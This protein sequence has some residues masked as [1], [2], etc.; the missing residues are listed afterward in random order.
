[1]KLF[2]GLAISVYWITYYKP[3]LAVGFG[4]YPTVPPLLAA[5]ICGLKIII[6]EQ[7]SIMG[8]ANLLLSN[9]ANGLTKGFK[10]IYNLP[11]K[12]KKKSCFSGNPIR[13]E[14]TNEINPYLVYNGK[15]FNILAGFNP[16]LKSIA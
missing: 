8:R 11:E 3:S 4:G 12:V 13:D 15:I 2:Y 10:D 14:V 6:H 16:F 9:F 7:N 1:M 5:K